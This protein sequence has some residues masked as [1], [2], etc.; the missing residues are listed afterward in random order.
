MT[1][2]YEPMSLTAVYRLLALVY[3]GYP[4]SQRSW[5]GHPVM[6]ES[7]RELR[8][9]EAEGL[10]EVRPVAGSK[11]WAVTPAGAIWMLLAE[12][13]SVDYTS[14]RGITFDQFCQSERFFWCSFEQ[15]REGLDFLANKKGFAAYARGSYVLGRINPGAARPLKV[16]KT[17]AMWKPQADLNNVA[18][19]A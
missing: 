6:R 17:W 16:K 9:L 4:P 15:L 13:A 2:K 3:K 1:S 5:V 14:W 18:R 7:L 19:S 8:T 11:T 12:E 10:V